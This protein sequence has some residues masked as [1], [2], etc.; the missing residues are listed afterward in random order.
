MR[1]SKQQTTKSFRRSGLALLL[2][3]VLITGSVL[4][5]G[6]G[7]LAADNYTFGSGAGVLSV[8]VQ[9][10]SG[11]VFP[12]G[13][14][15]STGAIRIAVTLQPN[16]DGGAYKEFLATEAAISLSG[17]TQYTVKIHKDAFAG[18]PSP[19]L[20]NP[21]MPGIGEGAFADPLTGVADA[22]F[23][24]TL[25]GDY[26]DFTFIFN[27]SPAVLSYP[28]AYGQGSSYAE[29][30]FDLTAL[31][32]DPLVKVL[33]GVTQ[34]GV[35]PFP[36]IP[37]PTY[38]GDVTV[39][40]TVA[41]V[42]RATSS[43]NDGRYYRLG[44]VTDAYTASYTPQEGD[45]ILY[46]IKVS[47]ADT[48][49]ATVGTV[50]DTPGASLRVWDSG[51]ASGEADTGKNVLTNDEYGTLGSPNTLK[52]ID[53][54]TNASGW[55]TSQFLL[56]KFSE[57]TQ[58]ADPL[59]V[60]TET[61]SGTNIWEHTLADAS[62]K[63]QPKGQTGDSYTVNVAAVVQ[64]GFS[65]DAN[66]NWSLDNTAAV[67]GVSN[68]R[69]IGKS[70]GA[71]GGN[72]GNYDYALTFA[73][74]SGFYNS[75]ISVPSS[76]AVNRYITENGY[77]SARAMI[78]RQDG[79][80]A[81]DVTVRFYVPEGFTL[82]WHDVPLANPDLKRWDSENNTLFTQ[83]VG[84]TPTADQ[85]SNKTINSNYRVETTGVAGGTYAP[86]TGRWT[87]T[88][89]GVTF[90]SEV[91]EYLRA[92]A[93]LDGTLYAPSG[94]RGIVFKQTGIDLPVSSSPYGT[95]YSDPKYLLH[96]EIVRF[97][98]MPGDEMLDFDSIPDY[99]PVNDMR[100]GDNQAIGHDEA[101]KERKSNNV[102][103]TI[104]HAWSTPEGTAATGANPADG[105][106]EDPTKDED[107]WA[108]LTFTQKPDSSETPS[109]LTDFEKK[110]LPYDATPNPDASRVEYQM[111]AN[112]WFNRLD[113][114]DGKGT[115]TWTTA[116]ENGMLSG[117]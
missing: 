29:G 21:V 62:K 78:Y 100:F 85:I 6:I 95:E 83:I 59:P 22:S 50:T 45:V 41:A 104:E 96:A 73:A 44:N 43:I 17:R 14:P 27:T 24:G 117:V 20:L 114:F 72:T 79:K 18:I 7:A 107:D 48:A 101:G 111:Y 30:K 55:M 58:T 74:G 63:L 108:F 66:G 26:Y 115:A 54:A 91:W 112:V 37:I 80:I 13:I 97:T 34:I 5:A 23:T 65:T 16:N 113:S 15:P 61:G 92:D 81:K 51:A 86:D 68:T 42:Y 75:G 116:D 84:E 19:S 25:N 88:A 106:Q 98:P 110:V 94:T 70:N 103:V 40:K 57:Q 36:N 99:D 49:G 1:K 35:T 28:S 64:A 47:A 46:S 10:S 2:S 89:G 8:S 32:G 9:T 105:R 69:T 53:Y 38:D 71:A 87:Y 77:V 90:H 109:N 12:G 33:E 31:P 56:T 67:N 60:W 39:A 3:L 4:S 93:Y 52:N 82:N 76:G 11:G 102:D